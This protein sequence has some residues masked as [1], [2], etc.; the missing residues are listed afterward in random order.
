[1]AGAKTTVTS[2]SGLVIVDL[3][4][5]IVDVSRRCFAAHTRALEAAGT[6]GLCPTAA[7]LW[8]AKRRRARPAELVA[9]PS[10]AAA[11]AETFRALQEDDA[12]LLLDTPQPGALD[13]LARLSAARVT[14]ILSLRSN[15]SSARKQV[16]RLGI[17]ALCP[18]HFVIHTLAGKGA[19]AR[20]LV[21][22]RHVSAVIGDT[23]ADAAVARVV[24]APFVAV[25]SGIRDPERLREERPAVVVDDFIA[26]VA[27]V[28]EHA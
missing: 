5:P 27:W 6:T 8:A 20:Q 18:V 17:A 12:L 15:V 19:R 24:S 4:G 9:D 25:A 26:A 22:G 14:F 28:E 3:D 13:A 21:A 11:Y 10:R 2:P 1:M 7:E 23:E 16:D